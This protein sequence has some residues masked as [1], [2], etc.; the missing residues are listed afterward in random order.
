MYPEEIVTPMKEELTDNGF[1]ELL[2]ADEVNAQLAKKRHHPGNDQFRLRLL[3][4]QCKAGSVD[5]CCKC[6]E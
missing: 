6:Q 4:W 5:G 2:T 3:S 1:S